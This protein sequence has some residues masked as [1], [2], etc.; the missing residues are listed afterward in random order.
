MMRLQSLRSRTSDDDGDGG[1][2]KFLRIEG[3][4]DLA[5][6]GASSWNASPLFAL[7]DAHGIAQHHDAVA[8]TSKQRKS[9]LYFDT[10]ILLNQYRH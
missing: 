1:R 5:G 3:T 2:R 8:G 10:P 7:E 9:V 6:D 4:L